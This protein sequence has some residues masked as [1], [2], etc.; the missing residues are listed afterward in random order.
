MELGSQV[1]RNDGKRES[2]RVVD[3]R[4]KKQEDSDDPAEPGDLHRYDPNERRW[5]E[6][7][8]G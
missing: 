6:V 8:R 1:A 3:H 5:L 4:G 7:I 2:V